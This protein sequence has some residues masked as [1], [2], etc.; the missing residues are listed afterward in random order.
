MEFSQDKNIMYM[1]GSIRKMEKYF[2][3]EKE[4]SIDIVQRKG[5]ILN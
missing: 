2:I 1:H 4:Q 3:L 5:I